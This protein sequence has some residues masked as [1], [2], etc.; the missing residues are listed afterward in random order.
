MS[1][2]LI[3]DLPT[4]LFHWLFAL[5]F[6][7]AFGIAQFGDEHDPIFPYHAIIGV[8]LTAMLL[9]RLIWGGIGT[10]YARFASFAFGPVAVLQ[11]LKG[12]VTGKSVRYPGHNP[13]SSWAILAMF[14]L[15]TAIVASG[16]L[17]A[18]NEAMEEVHTVAAYTMLAIVGIHV[19]G[20]VVHSIRHRENITLGMITGRKIADSSASIRSARPVIGGAFFILVLLFTVG[21]LR[22]YD[23]TTQRVTIPFVGT[24]ILLAEEEAEQD[25]HGPDE[26]EWD[27]D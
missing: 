16:L 1:R 27:D 20:V 23:S 9:F 12:T 22:N 26:R 14:I 13:A 21:L 25:A 24:S 18:G 17:M 5:G 7:V 3:W 2:V 4:R 8:I 10:R 15:V 11:Y 19:L 6:L